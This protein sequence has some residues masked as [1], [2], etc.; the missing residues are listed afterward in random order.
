MIPSPG[1]FPGAFL[2]TDPVFGSVLK[3]VKTRYIPAIEESGCYSVRESVSIRYFCILGQS[4]LMRSGLLLYACICGAI[5]LFILFSYG[6]IVYFEDL[7]NPDKGPVVLL[8]YGTGGIMPQLLDTGQIDGFIIWEPIVSETVLGKIGKKIA[9]ESDLPPPGKWNNTACCVLVMRNE[10]I[11]QYPDIAAMISALTIAGMER[12]QEDPKRAENITANWVFGEEPIMSA[13]LYLSPDEVENESFTHLIFT[14]DA[15][16]PDISRLETEFE[17][18]REVPGPDEFLVTTSVYRRALE[19]LNGS[20]PDIP[21]DPPT[22][23]IGY[24][25]SSDHYAPLYVAIQDWYNMFGRYEFWLYPLDG[26]KGRPTQCDLVYQGDTA[27]IIHL[28]PG[29]V[30]GGV[31]TGIGQDAIDV[32]YLGSVPSELQ[33]TLGNNASILHS[34]NTGGTGLVVGNDAPCEDW[35]SFISWVTTRYKNHEPVI[36]ATAQ[37]SI[38]EEMI[39][40]ALEYEGIHIELYGINM[41]FGDT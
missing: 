38:Q 10:F 17:G 22:V 3:G 34:V 32:G 8:V 4:L 14:P 28:V 11:A 12:I 5:A 13:N 23:R 7:Q 41:G 15:E 18:T 9:T 24:L 6:A 35:D 27:A 31:M 36:L 20:V 2:F 40:E 29:Q 16:I 39:R 30:G 19:L 25:P 1:F 26:D 37:S 33:I 21:K